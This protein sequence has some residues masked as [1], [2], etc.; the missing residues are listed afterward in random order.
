MRRTSF[1]GMFFGGVFFWTLWS[2]AALAGGLKAVSGP[3]DLDLTGTIY[4]GINLGGTG[5]VLVGGKW[6]ESDNDGD[7]APKGYQVVAP[8]IFTAGWGYGSLTDPGLIKVY[9]SMRHHTWPNA[10]ELT[11]PYLPPGQQVQVQLLL[12]EGYHQVSKRI[13]DIQ[14][15]GNTEFSGVDPY[16]LWGYKQPGLASTVV[17]VSQDGI[18]NVRLVG[19]PGA[20]D[21]N[22]VLDGIIVS[23]VRPDLPV[24]TIGSVTSPTDLDLCTPVYYAINVG[25]DSDNRVTGVWFESDD[26]GDGLPV[27]YT[28]SS[29]YLL[30]NWAHPSLSDVDLNEVYDDIRYAPTVTQ[31]FVMPYGGPVKVQILLSEG[32]WGE[33]GKRLMDISIEGQRLWEDLDPIAQWGK[34]GAGVLTAWTYVSKDGILDIQYSRDSGDPNAFVNGVIVSAEAEPLRPISVTASGEYSASYPATAVLDGSWVDRRPPAVPTADY[35]LLPPGQTGSLTFDMGHRVH[36]T[37]IGLHNTDNATYGDYGTIAYH[38]DISPDASFTTAETIASGTLQSFAEGWAFVP[39]ATDKFWQYVR[40]Y[41]DDFGGT[42]SFAGTVGWTGG[43]LSEI[44]FYGWVPEPNS[45][46]LLS[47]GGV[48]L[49]LVRSRLRRRKRT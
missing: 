36:L 8:S 1:W 2:Q 38:I 27:G 29:S 3:A 30:R 47:L 25:G 11:F 33:T 44:V 15:E 40:F 37:M 18:L 41:V 20:V 4:Y 6:L 5:D 16:T 28:I 14:I 32:Y 42:K 43:G 9:D 48:G 31:Q 34:N 22:P 35:W 19:T 17:T 46:V 23:A 49:W 45:C 26:D 21:K 7:S 39:I 12:S 13:F 10:V 24:A